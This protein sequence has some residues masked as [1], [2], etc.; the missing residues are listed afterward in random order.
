MK[1]SLLVV[2]ICLFASVGCTRIIKEGA[3][4]A[5]GAKGAFRQIEKPSTSLKSYNGFIVGNIQDDF[6]GLMPK[7]FKATLPHHIKTQLT[8]EGIPT[9][10]NGKVLQIDIKLKY[11]EDASMVG[12]VFGPLEEVIAEVVLIDKGSNKQMAKAVCIGRSKE[13]VNKGVNKKVEGLAKGIVKWI[14][15]NYSDGSRNKKSKK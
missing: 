5:L 4:L 13:S 14:V 11:Y 3:G 6:H 15:N 1:R 2:V 8:E 9:R 10:N 7:E 12:Q